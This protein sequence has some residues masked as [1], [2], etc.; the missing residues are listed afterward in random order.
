MTAPALL[1]QGH[2]IKLERLLKTK[3]EQLRNLREP[4]IHMRGDTLEALLNA[5]RAY[6]RLDLGRADAWA[7]DLRREVEHCLSLLNNPDCSNAGKG[8]AVYELAQ[9]LAAFPAPPRSEKP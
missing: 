8:Q 1:T 5:A 3:R 9:Y 6:H 7:G 4:I 2:R